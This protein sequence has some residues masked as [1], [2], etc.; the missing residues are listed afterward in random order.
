MVFYNAYQQFC[1]PFLFW[2]KLSTFVFR[3]LFFILDKIVYFIFRKLNFFY[4]GQYCPLYNQ[5]TLFFF[6]L[7]TRKLPCAICKYVNATLIIYTFNYLSNAY[8]LCQYKIHASLLIMI[9]PTNQHI[10]CIRYFY[11]YPLYY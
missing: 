3:K 2:T 6:A 9:L 4:F 7:E 8:N 11:I 5:K 1:P 10:Q